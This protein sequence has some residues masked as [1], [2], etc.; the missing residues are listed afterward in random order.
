MTALEQSFK[1]LLLAQAEQKRLLRHAAARL[2]ELAAQSA[3]RDRR[4][5]T[6]E[7]T[8]LRG[9]LNRHSE[10]LEVISHRVD[11]IADLL[12]EPVAV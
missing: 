6:A 4:A 12:R 5:W 8:L 10:K 9:E 2:A 1:N 7:T 3:I 11:T